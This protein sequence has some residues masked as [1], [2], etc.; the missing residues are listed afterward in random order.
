MFG[1]RERGVGLSTPE[2]WGFLTVSNIFPWSLWGLPKCL[3][4]GAGEAQELCI[5]AT[6]T[7]GLGVG[8]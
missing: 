2:Y 1:A 8:R 7:D 6:G 4:L 3:C 5:L